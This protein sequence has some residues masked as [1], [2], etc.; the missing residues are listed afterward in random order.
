MM[1]SF[2]PPQ[3]ISYLWVIVTKP[4]SQT[5]FEI[6]ASKNNQ[7]TTLAILVSDVIGHVTIRYC[8]FHFL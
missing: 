4:L 5:I 1:S 2:S 8:V 6:F 3:A 7:V